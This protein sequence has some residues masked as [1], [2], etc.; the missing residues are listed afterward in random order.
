MRSIDA[1]YVDPLDHIWLSAA[2][3]LGLRI[4]RSPLG[5]ATTDGKGTLTIAPPAELDPDDCLAQIILHELCHAL[6]QGEDSFQKPDWGLLNDV[7]AAAYEGDTVREQATLRVQAA[8]LRRYGLRRLLGPTTEFRRFYDALPQDPLAGDRHDPALPLAH[9][10]M[11][12]AARPPF[13]KVLTEALAATAQLHQA[14]PRAAAAYDADAAQGAETRS[15]PAP[16]GP[17]GAK[18]P[19]LWGAAPAPALHK[20]GLPM[21]DGIFT[22]ERGATC[23]GCGACTPPPGPRGSYRCE[24]TATPDSPGRVVTP[25]A[26]ACALYSPP[27]DCQACAACCRHAYE[28]VPVG[29]NEPLFA[30]F[31]HLCEKKGKVL[32]VRRDPVRKRCAALDG[33]DQGPYACGIYSE[34]PSTCRDFTAGSKNCIE[35]R[36]RVGLEP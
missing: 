35:A 24:R 7:R 16:S 8:L 1:R 10:G 18:L 19:T 14:L 32:T 11:A 26:A 12:L 17:G 2:A 29:R 34:R 27:L 3:K 5:Y 21:S 15:E 30:R 13:A 4:E 25:T 33:P 23:G 28:L 36:R 9:A 20:S 22:A 6:V 31:S